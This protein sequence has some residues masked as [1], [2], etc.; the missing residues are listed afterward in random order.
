M[1][2]SLLLLSDFSSEP[3][4]R[5]NTNLHGKE[6]AANGVTTCEVFPGAP[7]SRK[8]DGQIPSAAITFMDSEHAQDIRPRGSDSVGIV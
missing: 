7:R 8:G 2:C 5:S 1:W 3:A 4:R 6:L